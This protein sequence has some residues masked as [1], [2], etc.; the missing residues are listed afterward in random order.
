MAQCQGK[1][2]QKFLFG[3]IVKIKVFNPIDKKGKGQTIDL[4]SEVFDVR[5][6]NKLISQAVRTSLANYRQPISS[7]KTRSEVRGGGRKPWRQKGTGNARAGS[8]RSPLWRGGGIT[9]GPR[10]TRNF[11]KRFPKKMSLKA[12]R[13]ALSE[14]TKN[15]RLIIVLKFQFDKIS[16]R[17]VQEFLEKLPIEEGKI[18]MVLAKTDVNLELSTANL[19]YIKTVLVDGLN[20]VDLLNYDYLLT[21]KEGIKKIE[22]KFINSLHRGTE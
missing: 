11:S 5:S 1:E 22:K 21:D 14:K 16:T 19:R 12:I 6:Q 9:F 8:S 7:V 20:L 13:M 18:L 4:S 2:N 10:N 15:K 17:S 3:V